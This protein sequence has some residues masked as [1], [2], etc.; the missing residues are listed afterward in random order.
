M[1]NRKLYFDMKHTDF[2]LSRIMLATIEG[3]ATARRLAET[4]FDYRNDIVLSPRT[5]ALAI[6]LSLFNED[7]LSGI[8]RRERKQKLTL[9]LT[10]IDALAP[11]STKTVTVRAQGCESC[12]DEKVRLPFKAGMLTPDRDYLL[13]V[14]DA[15]TGAELGSKTFHVFPHEFYGR[16]IEHL[17]S[18]SEAGVATVHSS[19]LYT[20]LNVRPNYYASVRFNLKY[21]SFMQAEK[22]P[23]VEIRLHF[24]D[25][26]FIHRFLTPECD[27]YD[28]GDYHVD[29]PFLV[30]YDNR[31]TVYA[32][33]LINDTAFAG[34]VFRT[35]GED[36]EGGLSGKDVYILDE[37][38][39]EAAANR[40]HEQTKEEGD[41][42]DEDFDRCLDAFIKSEKEAL[43]EGENG[44]ES[45]EIHAEEPAPSFDEE[46]Q[47]LVGLE[48]VKRKLT[49]YEK[50]VSFNIL[51]A[52]A[53]LP[54][55]STPL[56][57][58]FLGSPGTGKTT[59]AKMVGK[60][61]HRVGLLSK[62]HM[63]V[64]ERATLSGTHYGDHEDLTR[65]ALEE[66]KGGILFIDE[67]YQLFQHNDPKDPGRL[68][69]ETLLTALADE[70][71]RDWMLILAGYP[72]EMLRLFDMN[73]GLRSRI[74]EA[75]IYTFADFSEAELMEI[76]DRWFCKNRYHLTTDART[77]LTA[78]LSSDYSAR[79]KSFGNA[80]HVVNLIETSILPTMA[81]RVM[82]EDSPAQES[83]TDILPSDIPAPTA[84]M[85][86]SR[87]RIG[88]NC[89]SL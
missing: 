38:S 23:E 45:E 5:T 44:A 50:L 83:L 35:E 36:R 66:A 69:L 3:R 84:P 21:E 74:P 70:D 29:M 22:V 26:S 88:F 61:L 65:K 34:V 19:R 87:R 63:V 41:F 8:N 62:G 48:E 59:V 31:G 40:F 81:S 71:N 15:A 13:T 52:G 2:I 12:I 56:H 89:Q 43:S 78:R 20:V 14:R 47:Q 64:R 27:D 33:A 46:L 82:G 10:D 58:M 6:V 32:E 57:A 11:L 85:Q 77:A 86:P 51:R 4:L 72:D 39:T 80:R 30:T 79:D 7:W 68:V 67:A 54:V 37:Y 53:G 25:G 49:A 60:M 42:T 16:R 75:N 73:P 28:A 24:P 1:Y 17:Y 76:A 55:T 9:I 18:V